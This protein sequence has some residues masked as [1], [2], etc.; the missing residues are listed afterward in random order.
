MLFHTL[1]QRFPYPISGP[2][3]EVLT[4][5]L[6]SAPARPGSL[7]REIDADLDVIVLKTLEKD[8]ARRYQ[9]AADLAGDIRR[10]LHHQPIAARPPSMVYQ[11]RTFAKRN[12][13]LVGGVLAVFFALVL[14]LAGTTWQAIRARK[15]ADTAE[16]IKEFLVQDLLA[17]AKPEFAP[18]RKVTVEE[19][20]ANASQRIDHAFEGRPELEASI[21]STLGQVYMSLGMYRE[22][23]MQLRTAVSLLSDLYGP[24]HLETLR[25][26]NEW[27][28]AGLACGF[29][30]NDDDITAEYLRDCRAAL[31]DDHIL[32]LTAGIRRAEALVLLGSQAHAVRV[33]GETL[34]RSRRTLGEDHPL[35]IESHNKWAQWTLRT[36]ARRA[37]LE[38][39]L[40][41]A[42]DRSRL[43]LGDGHPETFQAMVNLGDILSEQRRFA[44]AEPLLRQG[45]EGLRRVL[46][47]H[48]P[49]LVFVM[50]DVALL[51]KETGL[52][53]EAIQMS[54]KA[55]ALARRNMGEDHPITLESA[56][57][58]G[59]AL[60]RGGCFSE[61]AELLRDLWETHRRVL[62]DRALSTTM[63]LEVYSF[64]LLN[65]GRY[66]EAEEG[67]RR[68]YGARV[69]AAEDQTVGGAW[70]LRQLI[71][72]L[73]V[74][75]RSAEARPY[76]GR[77]LELR[78]EPA[79]LPDADAY[80][81]NCYAY[82]LLTVKPEDLRQPSEA[83]RVALLAY[84][85]SD[86][87][88]HFNR[89]TLAMAY[90][91]SGH[92][93]EAIE[94]ARRALAYA[95]LEHSTERAEYETVL[96]R[97]LEKTGDV[98]GAEQVY[99]DTLAAR[100]AQ[101]PSSDHDVAASLF[102]LGIELLKHGKHAEAEPLLRECLET[103]QGLL[104]KSVEDTCTLTLDCDIARTMITIGECLMEQER[105]AEAKPLFAEALELFEERP[106]IDGMILPTVQ[107]RYG[108]CLMRM[109][110]Y[111]EAQ[112]QLL[113]SQSA[114]ESLP[115]ETDN[116]AQFALERIIELYEEWGKEDQAVEWRTRLAHA[117]GRPTGPQRT[118][119]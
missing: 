111:D 54:R 22:A 70:C 59:A 106:P 12:K 30:W 29:V 23:E 21:R 62:G 7:H 49:R 37:E 55:L 95:P 110:R 80:A 52:V 28:R 4:H 102:A 78:R 36:T 113:A 75:G 51:L 40:R 73:A 84:E 48:H 94:S 82:D 60:C 116:L 118:N 76:G 14:G 56:Y 6:E 108:E 45:Y 47:E 8:P 83:L 5:I 77:M 58:V 1:T 65:L 57:H 93:D 38:T 61:A 46:G 90:E 26:R 117:S 44:E 109:G 24:T 72:S 71:R 85:R 53:G 16:A 114:F 97:C 69:V 13:T 88:Y 33:L 99:R 20:L 104:A 19:V 87:D 103:Q 32:T 115:T 11:L 105:Y 91:A 119:P 63:A 81:L 50:R 42:L 74:Q 96:V 15:E 107:L 67:F 39:M 34:D 68:A 86:D 43:A 66:A 25:L 41:A 3:R 101:S 9:S 64:S 100:R 17:S 2:M 10:Y 18:G 92:L 35:T 31:G 27:I 98:E 89:F 112:P 79:L